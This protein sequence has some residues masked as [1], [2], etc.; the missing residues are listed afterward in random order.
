MNPFFQILK[1]TSLKGFGW[2]IQGQFDYDNNGY[3]GR[4]YI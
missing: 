1:P 4:I 3:L 2:A